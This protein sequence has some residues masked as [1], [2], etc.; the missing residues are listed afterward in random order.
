MAAVIKNNRAGSKA[1]CHPPV[2]IH[3]VNETADFQ[4]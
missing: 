1:L 4:N 2:M 3:G